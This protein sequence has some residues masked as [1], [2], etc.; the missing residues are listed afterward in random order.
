MGIP[1][2]Q[3][4]M[5]PVLRFT[6]DGQEH[7]SRDIVSALA[8]M[9]GLTD[10][11]RAEML[12]SGQ[13]HTFDNRVYWAIAHM[14]GAGLLE[15]ARR[16]VYQITERGME[17]LGQNPARIDIKFLS[18]YPEFNAFRS[19]SRRERNGQLPA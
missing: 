13:Q 14:K 1:D 18:R 16:G 9:F 19:G 11:E 2:F 4:L 10:V 7:T 17:V 15:S 6:A 3:S 5:L 12:P 8:D